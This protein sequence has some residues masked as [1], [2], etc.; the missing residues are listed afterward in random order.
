MER[1]LVE[2]LNHCVLTHVKHSKRVQSGCGVCRLRVV[3]CF[4]LCLWFSPRF[5]QHLLHESFVHPSFGLD[6]TCTRLSAPVSLC[7]TRTHELVGRPVCALFCRTERVIF[8]SCEKHLFVC[9]PAISR[10]RVRVL[11]PGTRAVLSV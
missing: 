8:L 10:V 3:S 9:T 4:C 7:P 1:L 5:S 11:W 2:P 6:C